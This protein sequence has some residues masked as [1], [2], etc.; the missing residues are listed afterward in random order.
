MLLL[1]Q[2]FGGAILRAFVA[3]D[4][5]C[6]VFPFAGF[7]VD[8]HIHRTNFQTFAAVNAFALIAMDA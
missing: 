4:A 7:L 8:L 2:C 3:E 5:F 6:T 1:M